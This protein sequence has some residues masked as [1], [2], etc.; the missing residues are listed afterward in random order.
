MEPLARALEL[1]RGIRQDL[2]IL[3]LELALGR[4]RAQTPPRAES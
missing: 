4:L 1:V 2:A 3:R